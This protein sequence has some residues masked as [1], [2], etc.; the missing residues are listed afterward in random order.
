MIRIAVSSYLVA[1]AALASFAAAQDA[2]KPDTTPADTRPSSRAADTRP[3]V[4]KEHARL[5]ITV[6][7]DK[8]DKDHI[9]KVDNVDPLGPGFA[10]GIKP[11]DE[12]VKVAGV[13]IENDN[14][15]RR[16]MAAQKIGTKIPVVVRRAGKE[17]ELQ[18][19]LNGW[20]KPEPEVVT[21]QHCLIS[22]ATAKSP[23]N[24]AK[25]TEEEAKRLAEEIKQRVI[26]GE[27][28]GAIIKENTDDV[29]SKN[30]PVPGEYK[31]SNTGRPS[32][33]GGMNK[34]GAQPGFGYLCY[35]LAVGEVQIVPYNAETSAYGFHVVR[36]LN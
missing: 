26:A 14:V 36:R 19:D 13:T 30:K 25:R 5:G 15:Y 34:D 3:T 6:N 2:P 22:F 17:E 11:G 24:G 33:P 32:P 18:V 35:A 8:L 31:V 1:F 21:V 28:F 4:I 9:A 16:T 27:D 29:G 23:T 10:A 12:I 20:K 7:A